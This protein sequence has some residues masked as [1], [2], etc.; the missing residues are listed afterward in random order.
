MSREDPVALAEALSLTTTCLPKKKHVPVPDLC[1]FIYSG[2]RCRF[3]FMDATGVWSAVRPTTSIAEF[4]LWAYLRRLYLPLSPSLHD[5]RR[6]VFRFPLF[7]FTCHLLSIFRRLFYYMIYLLSIT[8]T[9]HVTTHL[10]SRHS[11]TN[12][13]QHQRQDA[14]LSALFHFQSGI[15]ITVAERQNTLCC[16]ANF[17][18]YTHTHAIAIAKPCFSSLVSCA[19]PRVS[20]LVS[21]RPAGPS[22][23]QLKN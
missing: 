6:Y 9:S 14:A 2:A 5:L 4:G 10:S 21:F 1:C 20:C 11:I 19:R 16:Y 15:V 12:P 23:F 13:G 22:S 18:S 7:I 8:Y 3:H 17:L